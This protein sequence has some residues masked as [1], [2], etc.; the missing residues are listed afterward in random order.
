LVRM[1]NKASAGLLQRRMNVDENMAA[2]IIDNLI[3]RHVISENCTAEGVHFVHPYDLPD[4]E[5]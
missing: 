5:G 2:S 1:E 4:D 3:Y